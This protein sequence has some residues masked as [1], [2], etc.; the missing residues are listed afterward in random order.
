MGLVVSKG[1]TSYTFKQEAISRFRAKIED[2]KSP[3]LLYLGDLDPSGYDI[4]RCLQEEIDCA[5]VKRIGLNFEDV[6]QY[7]LVPNPIKNGDVR[8]KGFKKMFPAAGDSAYELDALPPGELRD[9]A[10]RNILSYFDESIFKVHQKRLRHWRANF[11]DC[12]EEM[13]RLLN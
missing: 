11:T 8:A 6:T 5:E 4:F 2:W 10:R 1:Y 7:G 13:K 12:Q 9:R 3:V